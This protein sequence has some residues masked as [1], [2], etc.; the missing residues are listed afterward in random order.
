M[1]ARHDG[2]KRGVMIV[3]TAPY[4]RTGT[5]APFGPMG[6]LFVAGTETPLTIE[7]SW[8]S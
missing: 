5:F 3:L 6:R 8:F 4:A 7:F 1:C 2:P